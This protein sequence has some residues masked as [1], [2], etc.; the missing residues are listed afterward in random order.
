[1]SK[2]ET[3]GIQLAAMNAAK[4][5]FKHD[6]TNSKKHAVAY[7]CNNETGELL[8]YTRGEHADCIKTFVE[9]LK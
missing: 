2:D 7:L 3:L 8:V 1:M 5:W 9:G 6:P 4:K